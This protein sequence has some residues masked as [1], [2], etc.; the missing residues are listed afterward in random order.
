MPGGTVWMSSIC[1][2]FSEQRW[3]YFTVSL[4]RYLAR[5]EEVP[6]CK[7][8]ACCSLGLS[9]KALRQQWEH[10]WCSDIFHLTV[11][12]TGLSLMSCLVHHHKTNSGSWLSFVCDRSWKRST[13]KI[14]LV[15][16]SGLEQVRV[17]CYW[18][19]KI[20]LIAFNCADENLFNIISS[21]ALS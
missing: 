11:I 13:K 21:R 18:G 3:F 6:W 2:Y 17:I 1:T 9:L 10:C 14:S 16:W 5:S 12:Q 7:R 20:L 15:T 19:K 8:L 4:Q